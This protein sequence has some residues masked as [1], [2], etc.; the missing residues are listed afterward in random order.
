MTRTGKKAEETYT[1]AHMHAQTHKLFFHWILN[2]MLIA[3]QTKSS[4]RDLVQFIQK[5]F[6]TTFQQQQHQQLQQYVKHIRKHVQAKGKWDEC[7]WRVAHR[8]KRTMYLC[9]KLL[10]FEPVEFAGIAFMR[11]FGKLQVVHTN[12]WLPGWLVG[13]L[14][15]SHFV[16][17][18]LGLEMQ[19]RQ[20]LSQNA[21]WN[22][23]RS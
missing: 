8:I 5:A 12:G 16:K 3:M 20:H 18:N 23:F 14:A 22:R 21:I 9:W 13:W 2:F 10:F 17:V 4:K 15:D 6:S 11:V 19:Q 1:H 7:K